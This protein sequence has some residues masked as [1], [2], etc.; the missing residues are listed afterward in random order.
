MTSNIPQS[1]Y[2]LAIFSAARAAH[3]TDPMPSAELRK[4]RLSRLE[5]AL[6]KYETELIAAMNADFRHRSES[7]S[8]IFD[9]TVPLG[10]IRRNRRS[11]KRWMKPRRVGVPRRRQSRDAEAIG[12]A[13]HD[14]SR[15]AHKARTLQAS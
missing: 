3:L 14:F 11:V 9:I 6:P 2:L 15:L 7:D 8:G 12:T 10:D 4:E 13:V 1:D 5:A